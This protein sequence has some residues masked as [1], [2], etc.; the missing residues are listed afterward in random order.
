MDWQIETYKR[1]GD[2]WTFER[3]G[4]ASRLS[5]RGGW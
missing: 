4:G 1:E 5:E 3:G 2:V